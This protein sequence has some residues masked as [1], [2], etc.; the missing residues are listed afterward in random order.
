MNDAPNDPWQDPASL[1][2]ME[3]TELAGS[4]RRR[5]PELNPLSMLI[6]LGYE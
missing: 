1:K 4:R 6:E 3:D 2:G 5:L